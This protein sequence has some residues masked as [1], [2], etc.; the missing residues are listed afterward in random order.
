[1]INDDTTIE[2]LGIDVPRYIEADITVAD[3]R[4]ITQGGCAS[5]AYMPAV[6]YW[7]AL[8]TMNDH[9]DAVFEAIEDHLGEI[10]GPTE[11]TSWA[12]LAVHY[13]STAVELWACGIEDEIEDEIEALEADDDDEEEEE[14]KAA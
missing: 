9:G 10:P 1:M 12:G 6:T 5:G 4:A 8:K 3:V 2:S 7:K 13:L 14:E 11:K